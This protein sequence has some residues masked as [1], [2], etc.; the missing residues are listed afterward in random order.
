MTLMRVSLVELLRQAAMGQILAL[1]YMLLDA[2]G[3]M[4]L[5]PVLSCN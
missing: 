4:W 5:R 3:L 2:H 1:E